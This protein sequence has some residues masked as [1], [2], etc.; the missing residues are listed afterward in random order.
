ADYALWQ[1]GWLQEEAIG[2]QLRYWQEQLAG[3]P[4]LLKLPT[5]HPRPAMQRFVGAQQRM[6]LSAEVLQELKALSQREGVTLFMTLLAAFQVLLL[7]YT[8]Q[9]DLVVGIPIANRSRQE[10]EGLIGFFVNTLALRTDLSGHPSFRQVLQR[11]REVALQAYAHQDVPFEKVVE[12]LELERSLSYTP[13]FQVFFSLQNMPMSELELAGLSWQPLELEQRTARFDLS[14][15]LTE[16]AQGLACSLEYNTDLFEAATISRLLGHWHTLLE[17]VVLCIN[18]PIGQIPLLTTAEREQQL[19]LWNATDNFFPAP[20]SLAQLF[21]QQVERTPDAVALIFERQQVTYRVLDQYANRLAHY[22]SRLGVVPDQFVGVAMERSLELVVALLGILKAGG[23]YLPLDPNYPSERLAYM[24]EDS[25][26]VLLLTQRSLRAHLP[27]TTIPVLCLDQLWETS[28][29]EPDGPLAISQHPEHLAYVIYTSGSTGQ[30][31]GTMITQRGICNSLQWMQE[32]YQL[33]ERDC[34][35]QKT[36]LSFDPS[37]WEFFWPLLTGARLVLARPEGQADHAY[38]FDVL[39]QEEVTTLNFAPSELRLFVEEQGWEQAWSVRRVMCGG[40][41]LPA[42]LQERFSVQ[43]NARLSNLYGP[44][45]AT[46]EASFWPCEAWEQG[47]VPIGRPIHNV[48]LYV[49]D[50]YQEPVPIG[51]VGELYIGGIGLARGYHQR[52]DLTA[53]RFVPHPFSQE[54]GQRLYRTGD[55][56]RYRADGVLMF[57]GRIDEQVK[58]RGFRIEPGEIEAILRTHPSVRDALVMLHEARALV[59]YV[60]THEQVSSS[61]LQEHLRAHVPDYMVPSLMIMLEAFPLTRNGKVDRRA[62]PVPEW[63]DLRGSEAYIQPR[64]PLEELL[65]HI[66]A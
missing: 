5:D 1:R 38:L 46:I 35:L 42:G 55:L 9:E 30:P 27:A 58:L 52:P 33:T 19:L 66:W 61:Q 18:R 41:A 22:L 47:I 63:T 62:L 57:Q 65:A 3:A 32:T 8:G 50:A 21:E 49:L 60:T 31:K 43:R 6:R 29:V 11:V 51:V 53:E 39:A 28:D 16:S 44:T 56:V 54:S 25:R 2:S 10:L 20:Y 17:E 34:I 45:E 7:R 13:L 15:V 24:L 26:P 48:N 36:S 4:A 59:A 40:E 64:T 12:M 23:A 14:L 37:V